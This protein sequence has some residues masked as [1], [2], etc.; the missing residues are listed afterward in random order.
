MAVQNISSGQ[1][2]DRSARPIGGF[3]RGARWT[4][5]GVLY[6]FLASIVVQVFLAGAGALVGPQWWASHETM[7]HMIDLIVVTIFIVGLFGRLPGYMHGLNVLVWV[8]YAMQYVFLHVIADVTGVPVLRAL[9]AANALALFWLGLFLLRKG[10][11]L[12]QTQPRA[13]AA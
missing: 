8:L 9:H 7:G 4:Y 12:V 3:V 2:N 1:D 5:V 10:R 6:I 13:Q 11:A